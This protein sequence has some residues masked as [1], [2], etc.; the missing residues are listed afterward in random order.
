ML[1]ALGLVVIRNK[2]DY[3]T[4]DSY[5]K[6]RNRAKIRKQYNQAPHLTQD[7]LHKII[8]PQGELFATGPHFEQIWS[9][10]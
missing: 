2:N 10:R 7:K 1:Q 3:A 6:V 4:T 9:T 5:I 8:V